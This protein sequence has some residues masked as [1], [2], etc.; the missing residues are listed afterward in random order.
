[1][2]DFSSFML[3]RE[4]KI[5]LAEVT[6]NDY[7]VSISGFIG[8]IDAIEMSLY[9]TQNTEYLWLGFV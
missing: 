5:I 2:I 8:T 6:N 1:M 3:K 9:F 7:F 4:S